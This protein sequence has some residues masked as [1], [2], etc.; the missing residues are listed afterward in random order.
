MAKGEP[1]KVVDPGPGCRF[2]DRCPLVTD[3]CRT[4]TPPLLELRPP[5]RPGGLP[6]GGEDAGRGGGLD[7]RGTLTAASV[8]T[9][10]GRGLVRWRP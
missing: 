10:R 7:R 3:V 2:A 6:R 4:T 9:A 1:P 5:G 8:A